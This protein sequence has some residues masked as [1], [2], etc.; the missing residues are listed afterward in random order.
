MDKL[1]VEVVKLY[2]IC[3]YDSLDILTCVV[4]IYIYIL[5]IYSSSRGV[6]REILKMGLRLR[7]ILQTESK[8]AATGCGKRLEVAFA[9]FERYTPTH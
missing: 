2:K 8:T 6:V 1:E 7:L 5:Y 9:S 4:Y 3:A